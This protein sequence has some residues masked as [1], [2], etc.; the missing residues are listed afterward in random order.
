MG[1]QWSFLQNRLSL[2]FTWY[3]SN[4]YNQ[5][6]SGINLQLARGTKS[7][8]NAGNIQ[9]TGIEAS[10]SYKVFNSK[11]LTWNTTLNFSHN[12]NRIIELFD[13]K[14]VANVTKESIYTLG[15]SGSYTALRLDGSFGDLYGR[16]FKTDNQGRVIVNTTTHLPLFVDSIF[17]NPNPKYIVGWN[18][19]FSFGR[20]NVNMLI[21]GKFGGKVL[22]ITQGYLD[23]MGVSQRSAD[24]RNNGN[25]VTINNAVDEGG[26]AWSGT[27][28]AQTYYKYIGGKTPAGAAYTYSATAVRMREIAISYQLPFNNKVV[29]D[30][31]VALIGNNLF[32]FKKEAPFDP[33]QV[34]GVN[35]GGT[36][37]D[38]FGLPAYRSYGISLKCTF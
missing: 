20:F 22:S 37:I 36:G 13:P 14:I 21:D 11:K 38:A 4:T 5:Y 19:N 35:A 23:Q 7:D 1:T 28:D 27:V 30:M 26:H 34:A 2:D 3:K 10:V 8:F 31:R 18:N 25:T 12:K 15:S 6:F 24:A 29:K 33:E 9:N 32:F 16:T 17:A